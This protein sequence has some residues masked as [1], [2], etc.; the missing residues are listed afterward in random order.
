MNLKKLFIDT[1]FATALYHHPLLLDSSESSTEF[2]LLLS[3]TRSRTLSSGKLHIRHINLQ[4]SVT[5]HSTST[6]LC[7]WIADSPQNWFIVLVTPIPR[8]RRWRDSAQ[9]SA[10]MCTLLYA[11][12]NNN[13]F[14]TKLPDFAF[15]KDIAMHFKRHRTLNYSIFGTRTGGLFN[16]F[17]TDLLNE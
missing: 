4:Q 2:L 11:N 1:L 9:A 10:L 5:L 3:P 15:S 16:Q 8:H 7:T 14:D 17:P 13:L 12:E 6:V